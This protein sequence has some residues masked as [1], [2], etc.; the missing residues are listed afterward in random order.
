MHAE[1][2]PVSAT[3]PQGARVLVV[4]D[5]ILSL[6][7]AMLLLRAEHFEVE[8][9][10]SGEAALHRLQQNRDAMPE[11]L[12]VDMQMPGLAGNEL[13]EQLRILTDAPRIA[14]SATKPAA[15]E[16][17][18]YDGF[19]LKP[20]DVK[21]FRSRLEELHAGRS[22]PVASPVQSENAAECEGEVA[23][24][25][26]VRSKLEKLMP[27][28]AVAEIFAACIQDARSRV[29]Q[30]RQQPTDRI[31][32]KSMAHTIKGGAGMVGASRIAMIAAQLE[33][34]VYQEDHLQQKLDGLLSA[35]NEAESILLRYTTEPTRG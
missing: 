26:A 24:D 25:P 20:L 18:H 27:H 32:L 22:A 15:A 2:V 35:C 30:L 34:N 6:E 11:V 29:Q 13:A 19:L 12:L 8:G 1:P 21:Q 4:D 3:F 10:D 17:Q 23:W 7:I 16:L 31:A 14:M 5:D 33:S 9:V 28:A